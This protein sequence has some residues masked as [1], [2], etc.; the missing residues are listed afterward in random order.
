[1][2]QSKVKHH[3]DQNDIQVRVQSSNRVHDM[4]TYAVLGIM[5]VRQKKNHRVYKLTIFSSIQLGDYH[6][7]DV[8]SAKQCC[9]KFPPIQQSNSI[10]NFLHYPFLVI[11]IVKKKKNA[12]TSWVDLAWSMNN[13]SGGADKSPVKTWIAFIDPVDGEV[14][15]VQNLAQ[16]VHLNSPLCHHNFKLMSQCI[17]LMKYNTTMTA[18][19]PKRSC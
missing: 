14:Q 5:V 19:A 8:P 2:I 17:Y 11:C 16:L 10:Y 18:P 15:S 9:G 12:T 6:H 3:S 4:I 1:M 13:P 7:R